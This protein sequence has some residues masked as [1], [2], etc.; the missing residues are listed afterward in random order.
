MG[1]TV[2]APQVVYGSARQ[3][4]AERVVVLAAWAAR[5][6]AQA[7]EALFEVSSY[8]VSALEKATGRPGNRGARPQ[9]QCPAGPFAGHPTGSAAR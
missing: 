6:G 3:S 5:L 1:F 2:L 9:G 8:K 4:A 7:E